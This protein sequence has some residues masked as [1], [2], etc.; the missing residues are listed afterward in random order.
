M[1]SRSPHKRLLQRLM[2]DLRRVRAAWREIGLGKEELQGP[3]SH[4]RPMRFHATRTAFICCALLL[5][6]GAVDS[7]YAQSTAN[8]SSIAKLHRLIDDKVFEPQFGT[9]SHALKRCEFLIHALRQGAFTV[10]EPEISGDAAR[11]KIVR[12]CPGYLTSYTSSGLAGSPVKI[13]IEAKGPV[14]IYRLPRTPKQKAGQQLFVVRTEDYTDNAGPAYDGFVDILS[15]P[16][17]HKEKRFALIKALVNS[18]NRPISVADAD[19]LQVPIMINGPL[20]LLSMYL[21]IDHHARL[22]MTTVTQGAD[23]SEYHTWIEK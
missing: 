20:F 4:S 6:W 2:L 17:C 12:M 5:Y 11:A 7:A 13:R 22:N 18:G 9:C 1:S 15:M 21:D 8:E 23:R 19:W 3:R 14:T 16:G 10:I